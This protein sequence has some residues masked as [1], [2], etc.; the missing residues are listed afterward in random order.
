[1]HVPGMKEHRR[2]ARTRISASAKIIACRSSFTSSIYNRST[3]STLLTALAWLIGF[4]QR[5]HFGR[6]VAP[7]LRVINGF[8]VI[9]RS[10]TSRIENGNGTTVFGF[11]IRVA[12]GTK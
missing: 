10:F 11:D 1:M 6:T 4:S 7:V 2:L 5:A 12:S 9:T 8:L 3:L